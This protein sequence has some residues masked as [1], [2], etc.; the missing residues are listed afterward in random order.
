MAMIARL[1]TLNGLSV[2][3]GVDRRMV[4]TRLRGTKPDGRISGRDA[5][6][7]R[8][9]I[10]CGGLGERSNESCGESRHPLL[11]TAIE[12]L[13]SW[14]EIY[15]T[16][17]PEFPIDEVAR[18]L[19]V[20]PE[21][22]LTWLRCGAPHVLEG[23]FRTGKGFTLRVAAIIDWAV[24]LSFV[25]HVVD[26]DDARRRLMLKGLGDGSVD[27]SAPSRSLTSRER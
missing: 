19:G 5:W 25:C 13:D 12:R 11:E 22:I 16:P 7:L 14:R 17:A 9:F 24:T 23:D 3:T 6:Y 27:R 10:D 20:G 26:D 1:L 2:E 4:A 8:T 21:V 15:A 18:L